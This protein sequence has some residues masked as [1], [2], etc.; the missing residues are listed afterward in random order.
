M[1]KETCRKT[2]TTGGFL[3]KMKMERLCIFSVERE[4]VTKIGWQ[5]KRKQVYLLQAFAQCR[6]YGIQQGTL[7]N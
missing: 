7:K 2:E 4:V 6:K 3:V 5:I 1:K